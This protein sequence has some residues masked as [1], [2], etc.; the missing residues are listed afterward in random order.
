MPQDTHMPQATDAPNSIVFKPRLVLALLPSLFSIFIPIPN[1]PHPP[2]VSFFSSSFFA[3]TSTRNVD[4]LKTW[5]SVVS[6]CLIK[7]HQLLALSLSLSLSAIPQQ[8]NKHACKQR[9][10]HRGGGGGG[11]GET[12]G[13][14]GR[15]G[16]YEP[17]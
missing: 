15:E 8:R 16:R 4:D 17:T 1:T 6:E 3:V 2:P 10:R 11:G 13:V 5:L 7:G 9:R 12:G 14:G